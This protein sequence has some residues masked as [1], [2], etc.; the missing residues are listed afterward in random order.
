VHH[1][2]RAVA[3]D[4]DTLA[5]GAPSPATGAGPEAGSVYVIVRSGTSWSVQAQ[6]TAI[7]AVSGDQFGSGVAI[8][9]DLAVIAAP[10]TDNPGVAADVGN[11]YVFARSGTSWSQ[12]IKL[13]PAVSQ[14]NGFFSLNSVA[15]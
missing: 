8:D 10:F 13:F 11:A 9:G 7:D 2:G 6:L 3:L 1:V 4:G 12:E 5:V 15:I 14:E